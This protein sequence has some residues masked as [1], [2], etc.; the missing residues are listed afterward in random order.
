[1]SKLRLKIIDLQPQLYLINENKITPIVENIENFYELIS[2]ITQKLS[3]DLQSTEATTQVEEAL[4]I[5]RESD[6]NILTLSVSDLQKISADETMWWNVSQFINKA[7]AI[8]PYDY[9]HRQELSD[10]VAH[11]LD[12]FKKHDMLSSLL[13]IAYEVIFQKIMQNAIDLQ[14]TEFEVTHS[15][16]F[17]ELIEY[18]NKKFLDNNFILN[19]LATD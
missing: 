4:Q 8:D 14:I 16:N 10:A 13:L 6:P 12:L 7:L 17:A 1:M 19:I 11:E 5:A 18:L 15:D 2:L 3:L 9:V